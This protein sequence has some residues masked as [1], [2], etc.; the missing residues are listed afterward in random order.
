FPQRDAAVRAFCDLYRS[1]Q[2]EFP[3]ATREADYERRMQVAYPIH[4]ELFDRLYNDWSTLDKFQR[5]R[6]VLRL[7]A[8]VIHALWQRDDRSLLILP[9]TIPI[10]D[11]SVQDEIT[12]YMED[13]WVPVIEKD[14][15]GSNSRPL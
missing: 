4:P 13:Q 15:D 2:A 12:K 7:M 3:S 1:Q 10:D 8:A 11:R 6:G 9:A 14:V 5:T